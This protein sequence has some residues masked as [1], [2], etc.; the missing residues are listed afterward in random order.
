MAEMGENFSNVCGSLKMCF[1]H[2]GTHYY[3]PLLFTQFFLILFS[4]KVLFNCYSVL[5]L[6]YETTQVCLDKESPVFSS[7]FVIPQFIDKCT[8]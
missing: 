7:T 2:S 3:S 1:F 8:R 4:T 5:R 6:N